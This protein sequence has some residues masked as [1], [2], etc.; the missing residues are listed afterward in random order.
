MGKYFSDVVEKAIEDLYYCYDN[1]RAE[2]AADA[3]AYAATDTEE[4]DGDACY[5][6]ARCFSPKCSNWKYH[7]FQENDGAV[8][9]MLR[10]GIFLGSAAAVLGAIRMNMLTEELRQ[11]MP[12]SSI[13]DA[14]QLILEKAEDGCGFCQYMIGNTYYYLDIM[15]IEDRGEGDFATS[16]E[17][18]QWK[19][20][21]IS[22]SIPWYEKAFEGGMG[23]AGRN[24]YLYYHDGRGNFIEPDPK[25]AMDVVQKGARLGYPDWM[26]DLG[27]ELYYEKN[28]KEEGLSW[29]IEAAKQGH[30][31]GWAIAGDAYCYGEGADQD[32]PYALECYEK[33]ASAGGD[34]YALSRA[35]EMYFQG[36]G[37]EQDYAKAVKYLEQS[38]ILQ[39][40]EAANTDMLGMC[41]LLG[42]GCSQD[43]K[44]GK[45]LLEQSLDT[46]YKNFGLGKMYTE[47]IGVAEDIERGVSYLKAAGEYGPAKDAL[48]HYRKKIFGGWKRT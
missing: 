34:P 31:E 2:E 4:E 26:F 23:M 20:E 33:A 35:G 18:E 13:R 43:A 8:Y 12:F 16:D 48:R 41:Y 36:L 1:S 45:M 14:W 24:L 39:K 32:L 9:T 46:K 6:L 15:E 29:V 17:W 44:R 42:Y 47:G 19:K 11:I 28:Q 37:A 27:H 5:F 22:K 40:E 30:L 3:L 7:P 21:Q 38:Y 25:K 10:K